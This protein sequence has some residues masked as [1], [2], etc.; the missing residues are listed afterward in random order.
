MDAASVII[1]SGGAAAAV[2]L[3]IGMALRLSGRSFRRRRTAVLRNHFG[4]EYE[5]VVGEHRR[6]RGEAELCARI[7]RRRGLAIRRLDENE[8]AHYAARW[9]AAER[10]FVTAPATGVREADLL[11]TQVMRDRGYPLE[12]FPGRLALISVD[13]PEVADHFRAAH[14]AAVANESAAID[15]EDARQAIMDFRFVFDQL[16][17]EGE[18]AT[19]WP[20]GTPR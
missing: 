15:T 10:I 2:L 19:A 3:I 1:V 6:R 14:T 4:A 9:E 11:V 7:R 16:L 12:S 5:R 20:T 17:E 18:P 8:R 13:H